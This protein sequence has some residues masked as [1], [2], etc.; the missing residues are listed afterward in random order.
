MKIMLAGGGT[1]GHINPAIAIAKYIRKRRPSAEILFIGANN[2]MENK[3]VPAAGFELKTFPMSGM[4]RGLTPKAFAHNL[5]TARKMIGAMKAADKI[6]SEFAPDIIIGTGGFA[7]FPPLYRGAKRGIPTVVHESNVLPGRTNR[8]LARYVDKVL[9]GFEDGMKNFKQQEKLL[10]TG[11]PLREGM[12]F[13]QKDEAK[14]LLGID[15]PLVY[16][17]YGSLGAQVMNNLTAELFA[18]EEK[19]GATFRLIH[20]TGSFGA[21]WMPEKVAA[22]GVDLAATPRIDMR[23]YVY[24]AP[25]VLAAAD[26]MICRAGAMTMSELCATGTPAIIV[27]S[28]NVADDHQRKNARALSERGAAVYCEESELTA[29]KLY[30]I[31]CDLLNDETKRNAMRD[32]ALSLA[33]FDAEEQIWQC[34]LNMVEKTA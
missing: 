13:D 32:A 17:A 11:N 5:K 3:L 20:S 24:D 31:I 12:V 21:K 23:E 25:T 19:N 26:V 7:C 28:P 29:E 14:K 10:F 1:A 30:E 9:L 34:I 2:G 16:S 22:C 15:T 18:V 33:V 4:M 8:L 6:I 27:P